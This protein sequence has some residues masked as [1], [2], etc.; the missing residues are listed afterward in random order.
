VPLSTTEPAGIPR[1]PAPRMIDKRARAIAL[2]EHHSQAGSRQRAG[3]LA[4]CS[5]IYA[6]QRAAVMRTTAPT[7]PEVSIVVVAHQARDE[8]LCCLTAIGAA[9]RLPHEVIVIDD[10]STDGTGQAVAAAF[11]S[12]RVVA[13]RRNAGLP[14]GRNVALGEVHGAK[15]L[16]LDADTRVQP[17]AVE[18]LA[19]VLDAR[20]EVGLVGPKLTTADGE[21]QLS[22]RRWP[23][24]LIP[25]LRRGPYRRLISDDPPMHRRHLMK[26]FDH[27]S[28][29]AV[30]WVS[31]AAQ[32]WRATLPGLI[33][34][35]D[36]WVSS[37]G[38]EDLDWC[39]RVWEAGLAVRYVPQ[40]DVTHI[41]QAVNRRR[42]FG[43]KAWRAFADWY[44][45]QF[46]HRRLRRDPLL[47]DANT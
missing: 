10:G 2:G 35:Y 34:G 19:A 36:E 22:C 38:G 20:P 46:K 26:D 47:T 28:E 43:R 5:P 1:H 8:V 45:L 16:M 41:E 37:Y 27:A 21:L 6:A 25:V 39:L 13:M 24:F 44:Y 30:V 3:S 12:A 29:R 31:G 32:M 18:A 40:A 9:V 23:P 11:P 14:A 17:G 4:D 15:V 7:R 33:G 42:R